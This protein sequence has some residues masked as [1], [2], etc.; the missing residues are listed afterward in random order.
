MTFFTPTAPTVVAQSVRA[1]RGTAAPARAGRAADR[2]ADQAA[3][4]A[5]R[6]REHERAE[7]RRAYAERVRDNLA[8]RHPLA[9]R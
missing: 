2:A 3:D 8:A 5:E 1:T 9:L 4:R 7:R 6:R